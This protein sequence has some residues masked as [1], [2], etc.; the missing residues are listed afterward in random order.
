ML[1]I[2]GNYDESLALGKTD[3]QCGYTDPRDNHFARIS[4]EYT[5]AKTSPENK[6]VA[7]RPARAAPPPAR[8]RAGC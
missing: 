5:F 2:Q 1:A 6:R 8:R 4:Y 3:C 7:R